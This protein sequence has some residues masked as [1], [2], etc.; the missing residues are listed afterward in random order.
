MLTSGLFFVLTHLKAS[1]TQ[2][3]LVQIDMEV[4]V[5]MDAIIIRV[6]IYSLQTNLSQ[7]M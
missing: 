2:H 4:I 6:A 7:N 5:E 3:A 1:A